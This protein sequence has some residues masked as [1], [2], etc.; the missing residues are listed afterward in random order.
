[1]DVLKQVDAILKQGRSKE[2]ELLDQ[3]D[4]WQGQFAENMAKLEKAMDVMEIAL[5]DIRLALLRIHMED[6]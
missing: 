2:K 6:K 5:R 1:M 3:R 4:Y